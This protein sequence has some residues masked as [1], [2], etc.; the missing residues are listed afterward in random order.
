[1]TLKRQL[2]K[3]QR[4]MKGLIWVDSQQKM[5]ISTLKQKRAEIEDSV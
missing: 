2:E 5:E 3:G 1:M 4:D